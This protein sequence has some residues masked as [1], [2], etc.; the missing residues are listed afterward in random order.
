MIR[1]ATTARCRKRAIGEAPPLAT[2]IDYSGRYR[3]NGSSCG[4][5]DP[6]D[7]AT[8]L[9]GGSGHGTTHR[10]CGH[11]DAN[12]ASPSFPQ[13]LDGCAAVR[14]R[15]AGPCRSVRHG[16]DTTGP[17]PRIDNAMEAIE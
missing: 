4:S 2:P 15:I 10:I 13:H 9:E 5:T 7:V 11:D 12:G 1:K 14:R 17:Y 16:H 6:A 8:R 3:H